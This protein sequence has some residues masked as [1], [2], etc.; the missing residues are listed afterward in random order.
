MRCNS[1]TGSLTE[2]RGGASL[3]PPMSSGFQPTISRHMPLPWLINWLVL[4][5]FIFELLGNSFSALMRFN[6]FF[7]KT[8]TET[9]NKNHRVN[10]NW[11]LKQFFYWSN[12]VVFRKVLIINVDCFTVEYYTGLSVFF[13]IPSFL[14]PIIFLFFLWKISHQMET[15]KEKRIDF[16]YS[17]GKKN[18]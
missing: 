13:F 18:D 7:M 15:L 9:E 6:F 4:V 10:G 11:S 5:K 1:W 3:L 8:G 12:F 2:M 17:E 14:F 16:C